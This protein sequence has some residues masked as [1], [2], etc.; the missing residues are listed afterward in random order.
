M[1]GSPRAQV[2]AKE[3]RAARVATGMSLV[4]VAR[5]VGWSEAKVSRIETGKSGV[6]PEDLDDL[7]RVLGVQGE[8][9]EYLRKMARDARQTSWWEHGLDMPK[10][11]T[12]FIDAEQSTKRITHV[13]LNLIPGLLQTRAYTREVMA[14][15]GVAE[16]LIEERVAF[17][18]MRQGVLTR[19]DPVELNSFLDEAALV[20]CLGGPAVMAEQ[21]RQVRATS[22]ANNVNFRVL[23]GGHA[24]L[25]GGF[26][27]FDFPA[28]R[29]AVYL[30]STMSGALIE[31]FEDVQHFRDTVALLDKQASS[32]EASR[33]ILNSYVQQYESEAA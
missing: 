19:K 6:K 25:S 26:I 29:S 18:Q 14:V 22:E 33:E 13:S 9:R 20:R 27:L 8:E 7:L 2:L 21:L 4:E 17:R 24:A 15:G 1:V 23:R 32:A 11:Q 10:L 5:E 12:A 28:P 16:A 30:E 3:I 31:D